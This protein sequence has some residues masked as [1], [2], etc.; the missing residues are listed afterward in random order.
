MAFWDTSAVFKLYVRERD[1]ERVRAVIRISAET[2][3]ISQL[4]LA[5]MYRALWAKE[6]ARAIPSG[7]A[8]ATYQQFSEDVAAGVFALIPFGRDVQDE[9]ERIVPICYRASP[10]VPVRALDGLLLASALIARTPEVVSTD[11]RM[12]AAGALLG[13]RVLPA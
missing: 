6:F 12:R 13:L 10:V 9:F 1:S 11:S 3:I 8:D 4:S 2:P 5:E 7:Q